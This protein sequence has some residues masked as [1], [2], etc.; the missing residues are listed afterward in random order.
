MKKTVIKCSLTLLL[1][2]ILL[3]CEIKCDSEYK[4]YTNLSEVLDKCEGYAIVVS[5]AYNA[6][7]MTS[8]RNFIVIKD[9][10]NKI[11]EYQGKDYG[12]KKGDTLIIKNSYEKNSN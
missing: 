6:G 9:S 2:F 7:Y 12:V 10:N 1:S 4:T 5:T 8:H 3:G 11:Y